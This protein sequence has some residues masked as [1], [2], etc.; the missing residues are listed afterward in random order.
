MNAPG[1][2]ARRLLLIEDEAN[3]ALTIRDRLAS[4]GYEVEIESDGAVGL[5]RALSDP[6]DI[7]VLDL[8]LPSI[9][10]L[11]VCKRIRAAAPVPARA[12]AAL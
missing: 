10:G 5:N 11:E 12:A 2:T 7:V 8:M 3:V 9:G 4:E 6:P 1:R